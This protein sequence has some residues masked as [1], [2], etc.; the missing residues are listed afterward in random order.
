MLKKAPEPLHGLARD[1]TRFL[2]GQLSIAN[3]IQAAFSPEDAELRIRLRAQSSAEE[4]PWSEVQKLFRVPDDWTVELPEDVEVPRDE[5]DEEPAP[6]PL[7][8]VDDIPRRLRG[9]L[10]AALFFAVRK[11][12]K[13]ASAS[14]DDAS[15]STVLFK[16]IIPTPPPLAGELSK[17]VRR[18]SPAVNAAPGRPAATGP[19]PPDY[20]AISSGDALAYYLDTFFPSVASKAYHAIPATQVVAATAW[21]K[22]QAAHRHGASTPDGARRG[23]PSSG[24][25]GGRSGGD[26]AAGSGPPSARGRGQGTKRSNA[27]EGAGASAPGSRSLFSPT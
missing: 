7:P 14:A 27:L 21:L 3:Q 4:L 16:S 12:E 25:R 26:R 2:E 23:D 17:L 11:A 20:L 8:T 9:A 6:L 10:Q 19:P 18:A 24:R 13:P 22:Q 15:A 1:A 5:E